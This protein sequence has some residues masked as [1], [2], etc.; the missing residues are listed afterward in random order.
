MRSEMWDLHLAE[1]GLQH[2]YLAVG[3]LNMT[4]NEPVPQ[5]FACKVNYT[6][7]NIIDMFFHPCCLVNSS[8][9]DFSEASTKECS[10]DSS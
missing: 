10:C 1:N 4:Q 8:E 6:L 9:C 2:S 7:K 3:G 5:I